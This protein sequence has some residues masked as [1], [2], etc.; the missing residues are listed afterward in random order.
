M[1]L[2]ITCVNEETKV[3]INLMYR[4]F[5]TL[6]LPSM[7]CK[8]ENTKEYREYLYSKVQSKLGSYDF[9]EMTVYNGHYHRDC[10]FIVQYL[11]CRVRTGERQVKMNA[12]MLAWIMETQIQEVR[13]EYES[14]R[15]KYSQ[16]SKLITKG[17]K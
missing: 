7:T 17:D 3:G 9:S 16:L 6:S 14:E 2:I 5:V 10:L 15:L 13:D 8:V 1:K 4:P 11:L 12:S